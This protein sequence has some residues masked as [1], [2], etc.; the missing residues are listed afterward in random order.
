M[1]D[2]DANPVKGALVKLGTL[3]TT[4]DDA[5]NFLLANPPVGPDQLLFIDGGPASTP[6]KSFPIVPYKVTIVAGQANTLGF[7]PYLHFQ[8][9]TGLVDISNPT[10][11]CSGW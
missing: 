8:K 11:A 3:Q 1:L 4:T 7:T 2:E 6:G 10:P 9:T 5:G